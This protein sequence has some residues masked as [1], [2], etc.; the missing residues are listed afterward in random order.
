MTFIW[1]SQ[2]NLLQLAAFIFEPPKFDCLL[3]F[4]ESFQK[5]RWTSWSLWM[6]ATDSIRK[7]PWNYKLI[8]HVLHGIL[9]HLIF[10]FYISWGLCLLF[11][12]GV[13]KFEWPL[14]LCTVMRPCTI[15]EWNEWQ[16]WCFGQK[17]QL[18]S[19]YGA[20]PELKKRRISISLEPEWVGWDVQWSWRLLAC[21]VISGILISIAPHT[22]LPHGFEVQGPQI[23]SDEILGQMMPRADFFQT[24]A[25]LTWV[26]LLG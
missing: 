2:L 16:Q 26:P 13:L 14:L 7:A 11:M 4:Q 21:V 1:P 24:S 10:V 25:S 5:S 15:G 20:G 9:Y 3:L 6:L 19:C 12:I 23:Q 22:S 8:W 17:Q 18:D